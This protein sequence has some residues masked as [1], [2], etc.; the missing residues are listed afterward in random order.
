MANNSLISVTFLIPIHGYD[1]NNNQPYLISD[2]K[3]DVICKN[4]GIDINTIEW[5]GTDVTSY[6]HD[7]QPETWDCII[8]SAK[9]YY[10]DTF[11]NNK[12]NVPS[13]KSPDNSID[14]D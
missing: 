1:L 6:I 3:V 14:G 7:C 10:R 8:E 11:E 2:L 13:K 9:T 5:K 4:S 12:P